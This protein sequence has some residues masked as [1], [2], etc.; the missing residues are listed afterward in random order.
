MKVRILAALSLSAAVIGCASGGLTGEGAGRQISQGAAQTAAQ[1]HPKIIEEFGGAETG[2]RGAYVTTVGRKV[3]AQSGVQG[4]GN[5]AY[6]ITTLNSPVLNAFAVPGGY[7]YITRQLLSLMDDEA[8]LAS[9]LG[10]EVG[11]I[12][13]DHSKQ[14]SNRSQLSQIVSVLAGVVTGSSEVAQ[15]ANQIST[16]LVLSYSRS[17]EFEA[18]DLGIRYMA[19]AGYDPAASPSL[20]RSL[21]EATSL[22]TRVSG[23]PDERAIPSW[24]RTHPLSADRVTRATQ[25]AS[26]SGMSGRGARNRDAFLAQIDGMLVDDDPA[27]GVVEGRNFFHPDLRLR[28]TVPNGYGIQ[29]GTRAVTISGSNGQAMFAGGRYSGDLGSYI[30][31]VFRGL[32]G[33]SQINFAQP[34]GTT[35]NGIP[36]AYST[37]RVATQQGQLDVTVFAYQWD[38]NTA[39]HFVT[40]T[41]AGSG[42][43][44][45]SSLVS[46]TA[47]LSASEESAIRPRVIDVVTVRPGDTV[48][49]LAS[50]MAYND[51]KL[52]RFL[53]LNSL[54]S[55]SQ[56]RAGDKV[57]IVV[58]G[59]R[60]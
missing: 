18:D 29:N 20:L 55:N 36:A 24:A 4:G 28:F 25:R 3:A 26:Q 56:L 22:D 59:N 16:G 40:L 52:E 17:Q 47:R 60:A 6:T 58:Y 35:V 41:R 34:R 32:G 51:L 19:G 45:F 39:Y 33:Q 57:K 10:H 27:Q 31:Q 1:Q 7:V 50:R 23:G 5:G 54:A 2:A 11:H 44:P 37:A 38:V 8:E 49:S 43:G 30:A 46:S 53:V 14:R 21:G 9:V 48:Q 15:I 13:A 12:A 42:L